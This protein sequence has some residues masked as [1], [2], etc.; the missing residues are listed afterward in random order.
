M[1]DEL[2]F[3]V[4]VDKLSILSTSRK[5]EKEGTP[6]PHAIEGNAPP[7]LNKKNPF[8]SFRTIALMWNPFLPKPSF[9]YVT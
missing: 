1:V 8:F 3:K 4:L 2:G 7:R 5:P 9:I 6:Q